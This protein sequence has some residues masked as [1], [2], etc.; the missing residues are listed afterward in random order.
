MVTLTMEM[1]GILIGSKEALRTTWNK[2]GSS[3]DLLKKRL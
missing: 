2:L 3:K 1:A